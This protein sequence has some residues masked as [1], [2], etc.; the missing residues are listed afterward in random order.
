MLFRSIV[1]HSSVTSD[2]SIPHVVISN[3]EHDSVDLIAR[4]LAAKGQIGQ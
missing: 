2:P 1:T 3:L 4:E